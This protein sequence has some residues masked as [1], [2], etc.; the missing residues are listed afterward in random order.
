[1]LL[2]PLQRDI[3]GL[4]SQ[5]RIASGESYLAGGTALNA[6]LSAPRLS[7]DIDLFHDTDQALAESWKVDGSVLEANGFTAN[8]T[9]ER[10]TIVE[11]EV[12]RG[13]DRIRM[14]WAPDSAFRFFPI[15]LHEELG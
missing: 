3:C 4:L 6:L 11:A 1:M 5:N 15:E 9:R 7:G 10:P 14:E 2:T 12:A 8:P 13:P